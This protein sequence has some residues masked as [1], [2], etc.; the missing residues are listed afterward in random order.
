[1][2]TP[3]HIVALGASA[4]GLE[5]IENILRALPVDTGFAFV[6]IQHVGPDSLL[7]D[8]LARFTEIP[9]HL[10]EDGMRIQANH[11]Y[12]NAPQIDV[13]LV[14]DILKIKGAERAYGQPRRCIDFFMTSLAQHRGEK[15]IG[16]VLSGTLCD[17]SD[18]VRHIKKASGKTF[19]QD[20]S[21]KFGD[22]PLNAIRTGC[23]DHVL[24]PA[25]IA[26]EI[27]RISRLYAAK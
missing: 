17:G 18:G 23:V 4:G 6:V 22:M 15:S 5:P 27:S 20:E 12:V 2:Q 24:P 1:M 19:A 16:V 25:G 21:A 3:F 7:A 13:E 10:V 9:V 26:E 14:G 11:L 8:V